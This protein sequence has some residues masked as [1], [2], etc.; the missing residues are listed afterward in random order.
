MSIRRTRIR[1][2]ITLVG[3]FACMHGLADPLRIYAWREDTAKALPGVRPMIV[4]HMN[5]R[6][7][8][9]PIGMPYRTAEPPSFAAKELIRALRKRAPEDRVV[10]LDAAGLVRGFHDEPEIFPAGAEAPEAYADGGYPAFTARWM[11]EFW[12]HVRA[13]GLAPSFIV[14]DYE[15]APEFWGLTGSRPRTPSVPPEVP[16]PMVGTVVAMERL[17]ARLGHSPDGHAPLDYVHSGSAWVWNHA[18][19]M[20]FNRWFAPLRAAAIRAAIFEPAWQAF[21]GELPGSN[22][23][24][25]ERAWLGRDINNWRRE[26]GVI[27]GNWSSP[28]VY[29]GATGQR[30]RV[31]HA[32]DSRELQRALR[33]LDCRNDVR[34]ALARTP[35]VAPWYSNPDYGRAADE[36][37]I[38]HRLQWA[39]GLL[40]DR[41]IGVG[42]M[43]FWSDRA[44]TREEIEFA[45]PILEFLRAMSATRPSILEPLEEPTSAKALANWIEEVR[46]IT[47]SR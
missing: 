26:P 14:L 5:Y 34:S 22:Y 40:H 19:I 1:W 42:I 31:F 32:R 7:G 10:L 25:Q 29:L 24:E 9:T 6:P 43:F 18:A 37:V 47:K 17:Q 46:L 27:S 41:S 15:S 16:D 20:D 12:G 38:E 4:S 35:N 39:A 21:G 44:W 45:R 13:S 8:K 2:T 28:S 33:W 11:T 23:E 36:D 3:A 30:Y